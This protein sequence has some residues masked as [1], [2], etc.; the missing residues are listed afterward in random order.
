MLRRSQHLHVLML[1]GLMLHGLHLNIPVCPHLL[2]L[3]LRHGNDM[4]EA[5]RAVP[6]DPRRACMK[7]MGHPVDLS[8]AANN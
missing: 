1:H 5:L 2:R 3:W 7:S 6:P 8:L 4:L